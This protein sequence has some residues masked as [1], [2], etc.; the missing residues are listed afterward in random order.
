MIAGLRMQNIQAA[1]MFQKMLNNGDMPLRIGKNRIGN[2]LIRD[3]LSK[4]EA[5]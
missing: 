2:A 4:S 1:R 3:N 5:G